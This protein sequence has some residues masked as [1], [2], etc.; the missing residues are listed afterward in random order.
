VEVC[1]MTPRG[2]GRPWV[3]WQSYEQQFPVKL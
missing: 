3:A 1:I 2:N